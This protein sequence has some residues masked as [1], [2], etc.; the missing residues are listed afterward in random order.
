VLNLRL[1]GHWLLEQEPL[2]QICPVA[3][4]LPQL[5][6]L[7]GSMRILAVQVGLGLEMMVLV[8]FE[9]AVTVTP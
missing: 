2:S 8:I 9:V 6:Q 4:T 3:Q 5:P 1:L 7:R